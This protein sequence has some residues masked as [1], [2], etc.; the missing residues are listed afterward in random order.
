MPRACGPRNDGNGAWQYG[1]LFRQYLNC[2]Y[3]QVWA[4]DVPQGRQPY[5]QQ[6]QA[7]PSPE[8]FQVLQ[9]A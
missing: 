9:A 4:G 2:N 6:A 3:Y 1:R 5:Y 8:R 7:E